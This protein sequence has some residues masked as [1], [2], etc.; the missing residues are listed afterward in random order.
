MW[1]P[2]F[3]WQW[4]DRPSVRETATTSRVMVVYPRGMPRRW[5]IPLIA[6][7]LASTAAHAEPAGPKTP[8]KHL[9]VIF[10]ENHSFD[11]YFA[12]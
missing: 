6:V 11:A 4:E 10:Q 3:T 5:R 9:V 8:I 12:T 1:P 2:R 7:A